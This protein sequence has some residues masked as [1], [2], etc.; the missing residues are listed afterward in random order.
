MAA[1][2]KFKE[3]CCVIC[4]LGFEDEK[5]VAVAKKGMLT[6]IK[7]SEEHGENDLREHLTRCIN[8]KLNKSVLVHK[9]CR[10][11]FTRRSNSSAEHDIIPSPKKLRSIVYHHST[12]NETV[13]L[14]AN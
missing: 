4:N 7:C 13:Y 10:R 1:L 6:L 2:N 14:V 9:N 5:P 8:S 3:E 12:G 11:D